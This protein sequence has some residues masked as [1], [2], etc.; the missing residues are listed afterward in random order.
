MIKVLE[1]IQ[2]IGEEVKCKEC[3]SIVHC[4]EQDWEKTSYIWN[5]EVRVNEVIDCPSCWCRIYRWED[6]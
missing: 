1:G 3:G 4:E 5:D 2:N 6:R